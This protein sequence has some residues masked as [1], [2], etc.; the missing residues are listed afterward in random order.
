MAKM[1]IITQNI[2]VLSIIDSLSIIPIS[3]LSAYALLLLGLA[4]GY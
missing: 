2:S 4:K 3:P 1:N